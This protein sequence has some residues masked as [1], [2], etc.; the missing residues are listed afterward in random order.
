MEPDL[1]P[2]YHRSSDDGESYTW[3]LLTVGFSL[4]ILV[5]VFLGSAFL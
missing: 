2:S 1:Q 4:G 5:G 3:L